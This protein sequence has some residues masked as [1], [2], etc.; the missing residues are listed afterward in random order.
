MNLNT[1]W[2]II[3]ILINKIGGKLYI[4]SVDDLYILEKGG[5]KALNLQLLKVSGILDI[6]FN[7]Q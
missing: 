4:N 6:Q 5:E 7:I 1:K 2:W 3:C